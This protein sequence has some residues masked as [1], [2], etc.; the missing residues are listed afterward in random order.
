[1]SL[2]G[3]GYKQ[4]EASFCG[5]HKLQPADAVLLAADLHTRPALTK[6]ILDENP[7]GIAGG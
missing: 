5:G 1:M 7:L 4:S 3:I 6:L 2:C